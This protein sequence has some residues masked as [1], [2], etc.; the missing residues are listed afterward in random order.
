MK[1]TRQDQ[2]L[3][4]LNKSEKKTLTT[5]ELASFLNVTSM[6]IRRDLN[7][8]ADHNLLTRTYGGASLIIERSTTEKNKLQKH[9]KIEIGA[10]IASFIKKNSTIYLGSGTTIAAACQFLPL[11]LGVQYITNSDLVFRFLENK[12]ASVTLAGGVYDKPANQ[13]VGPVTVQSLQNYFFDLSFFG[14]NG[15]YKEK[16]V[17]SNFADISVKKTVLSHSRKSFVAV[18]SS[19]IDTPNPYIFSDVS[20]LDGIIVDSQ[21]NNH[22]KELLSKKTKVIT[23]Q[24]LDFK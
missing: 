9:A 16:A 15:I 14:A 1:I 23:A 7:E 4:L 12:N 8:L 13:F 19:K 21:I 24:T 22:K 2:I 17:N 10:T 11:N 20:E 3:S 5:K 18:D 6:T